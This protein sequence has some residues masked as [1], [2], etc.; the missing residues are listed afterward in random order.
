VPA[1]PFHVPGALHVFAGLGKH[2][3]ASR[4]VGCWTYESA[5]KAS[6]DDVPSVAASNRGHVSLSA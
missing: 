2:V 4:C 1:M 5:M 6:A 3:S